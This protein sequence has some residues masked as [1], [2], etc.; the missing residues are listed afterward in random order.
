[1]QLVLMCLAFAATVLLV[2]SLY[3]S[4]SNKITEKDSGTP[5]KAADVVQL[6]LRPFPSSHMQADRRLY[7]RTAALYVVCCCH[8]LFERTCS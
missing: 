6:L 1:M 8:P 2:L 5:E 3:P 4:V 7:W